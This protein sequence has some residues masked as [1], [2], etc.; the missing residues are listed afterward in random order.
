MK[1]QDK[2]IVVAL[3]GGVDSA[4]AAALL[5]EQGWQVLGVHLLLTEKQEDLSSLDLLCQNLQIECLPL[6]FRQ[7]FASKV[8][9]Y[10]ADLYRAGRTPNPCVR[11][12]EHIKFGKLLQVIRSWGYGYLATGH[13]AQLINSSG[14]IAL[15]RGVDI[16]KEQSYFLHRLKFDD[17]SSIIFPLGRWTKK[18]VKEKSVSL[19]LDRFLPERESQE[20][21]FITGKYADFMKQLEI[22]G[23][24][25][26]GPIV[27]R[28]GQILGKHRGVEHY[29][30][31]QRQ[32]LGLPAPA[33]YYVLEILPELNQIVVGFKE[34]LQASA[35]EVE[36]INWL[37]PPPA[38]PLR[39][40][41]RLRYRHPGVSCLISPAGLKNANIWLDYPQTAITPGQAAVFYQD[42][43][44]LGGGWIV[45]GIS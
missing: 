29:T 25:C 45:R 34:D 21:C 13:Y 19:G 10:F 9:H 28:S 38:E 43:Q 5:L 17:L 40:Q 26:S 24:N 4:V 1:T 31:G 6:D 41:V 42:E 16:S 33:P 30:V 18:Q 23:L 35:L 8:I 32:G 7:E 39:A 37:I 20:I 3:S 27:N 22:E 11:C 2:K 14:G 15:F 12:N 36:H 44:V